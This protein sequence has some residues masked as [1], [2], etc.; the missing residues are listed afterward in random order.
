MFGVFNGPVCTC[1]CVCVCARARAPIV[2]PFST[3][4]TLIFLLSLLIY[5]SHFHKAFQTYSKL[6]PVL[7]MLN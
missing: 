2:I 4:E 6:A 1:M 7:K 5:V 3:D